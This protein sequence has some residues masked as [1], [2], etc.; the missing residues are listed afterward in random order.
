MSGPSI[1]LERMNF[2]VQ[3]K[4]P[5]QLK[6]QKQIKEKSGNRVCEFES[7]ED[8]PSDNEKKSSEIKSFS[9]K[10]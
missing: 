4:S 8:N 10:L 2:K 7:K 5:L 1:V 3:E 9:K 6:G